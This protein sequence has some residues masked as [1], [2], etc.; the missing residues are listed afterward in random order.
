MDLEKMEKEEWTPLKLLSYHKVNGHL[1]VLN[2]M[3]CDLMQADSS[4]Y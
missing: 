1:L 4:N 2:K 3:F